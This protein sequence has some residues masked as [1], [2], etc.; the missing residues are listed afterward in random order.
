[1]ER[2]DPGLGSEPFEG[3]EGAIRAEMLNDMAVSFYEGL[4]E[5]RLRADEYKSEDMCAL[6]AELL[7][8]ERMKPV[9]GGLTYLSKRVTERVLGCR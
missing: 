6:K 7:D 5:Q 4:E 3:V 2:S 8:P 1:V 9:A